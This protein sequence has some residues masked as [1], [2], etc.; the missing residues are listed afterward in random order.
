MREGVEVVVGGLRERV[1]ALKLAVQ[2][3]V[4]GS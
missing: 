2:V 3:S 4:V 1:M